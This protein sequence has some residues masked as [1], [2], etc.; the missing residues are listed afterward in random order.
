V[1][2]PAQLSRVT[3]GASHEMMFRRALEQFQDC[4][5]AITGWRK[6]SAHA[7]L[8]QVEREVFETWGPPDRPGGRPIPAG[9]IG[10]EIV[11]RERYSID[12]NWALITR[13]MINNLRA[14]LDHLAY[15]L[16]LAYTGDP[17][18]DEAAEGS[19][20]PIFWKHAPTASALKK[21][22]GCIDPKAQ[23]VIEAMQPHHDSDYRTNKLWALHELDRIGKHRVLPLVAAAAT[24][25]TLGMP[26]RDPNFT[27]VRSG[28]F[29]TF[30]LEDGAVVAQHILLPH[31]PHTEMN[32][33]FDNA[34]DVAFGEGLPSFGSVLETLRALGLE[35]E[36]RVF[37][38]LES[39]L[40]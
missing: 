11:F 13:E 27:H 19:E 18:P 24:R 12:P 8:N 40:K 35:L 9:A 37:P 2:Q 28:F 16:A 33:Q 6:D 21:K 30:P 14:S 22:I 36:K 32:M 29:G 26:V 31:D 23:T 4:E 17:L 34:F 25:N 10:F 1:W 7:I 38:A 5:A 39:F 20:F 15:A 3:P